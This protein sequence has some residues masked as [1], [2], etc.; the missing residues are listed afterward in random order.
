MQD[1]QDFIQLVYKTEIIEIYKYL[2]QHNTF[3]NVF[4]DSKGYTALHAASLRGS[5][6]L[7]EFLITYTKRNCKS[8]IPVIQEWVNEKNND[9]FTALHFAAY[10]GKLV[11]Y[12]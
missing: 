6:S 1:E 7:F 3:P 12:K 9:G 8:W 2:R 4:K 11:S 10:R 5:Y